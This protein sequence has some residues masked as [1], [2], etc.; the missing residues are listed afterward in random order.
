LDSI[1][2]LTAVEWLTP[3]IPFHDHQAQWRDPLIRGEPP[4]AIYAFPAPPD[5]TLGTSGVNDA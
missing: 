4:L 5:A 3:T 2:D 1:E